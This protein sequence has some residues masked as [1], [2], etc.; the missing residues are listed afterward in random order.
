VHE[1]I[2]SYV[3]L[4]VTEEEQLKNMLAM[5]TLDALKKRNLITFRVVGKGKDKWRRAVIRL[6]VAP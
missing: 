3:G 5:L 1:Q 4:D 2:E 6:V